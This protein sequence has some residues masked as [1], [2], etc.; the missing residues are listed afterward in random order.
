ML[1]LAENGVSPRLV[2]QQVG[3]GGEIGA[4]LLEFGLP[5]DRL[6]FGFDAGVRDPETGAGDC[7][8]ADRGHR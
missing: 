5:C 6:P 3:A 7:G 1:L 4:Q 8:E 2:G